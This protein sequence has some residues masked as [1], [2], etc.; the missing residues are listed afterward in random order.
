MYATESCGRREESAP[1]RRGVRPATDVAAIAD[2][3]GSVP[4][5]VVA[6]A[7]VAVVVAVAEVLAPFMT[8]PLGAAPGALALPLVAVVVAA[9][10]RALEHLARR[11]EN[12]RP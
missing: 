12:G 1:S 5:V 6:L 8:T 4:I 7:V 2:R 10:A 11:D 3:S 9:P